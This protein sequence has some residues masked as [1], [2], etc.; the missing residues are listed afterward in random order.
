MLIFI[1]SHWLVALRYMIISQ[2]RKSCY[3]A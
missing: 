3:N 1:D 2:V